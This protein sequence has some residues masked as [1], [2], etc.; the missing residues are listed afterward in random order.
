M[1]RIKFTYA[2]LTGQDEKGL[3]V[4]VYHPDVSPDGTHITASSVFYAGMLKRLSDSKINALLDSLV[5]ALETCMKEVDR[6]KE[7]ENDSV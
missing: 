2:S 1:Y 4:I 7:L 5:P 3:Q 6:R